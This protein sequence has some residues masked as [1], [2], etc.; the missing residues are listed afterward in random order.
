MNIQW[1][2]PQDLLHRPAPGELVDQLV[3][4]ADLPHQRVFDVLDPDAAHHARD[5][6]AVRMQG[7]GLGKKGRDV[8]LP[9]DL[10]LQARLVIARQPADDPV[11][12]FIRALLSLRLLHVQRVDLGKGCR[13]YQMPSHWCPSSGPVP[14]GG[15]ASRAEE[16]SVLRSCEPEP[17]RE[18]SGREQ[19]RQSAA[20]ISVGNQG[21]QTATAI[22]V[23]IRWQQTA[24]AAVNGAWGRRRRSAISDRR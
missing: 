2:L 20:A 16:V 1:S 17:A 11:D 12:L 14:I 6:R 23:G 4:V 7:R 19:R 15:P 8:D 13:E 21:R 22:S 24:T 9:L 18:W 3:Q 5:Q 10:L